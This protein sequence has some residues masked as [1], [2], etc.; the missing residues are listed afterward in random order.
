MP[1]LYNDSDKAKKTQAAISLTDF[2]VPLI[3]MWRI[4]FTNGIRLQP[5]DSSGLKQI[6][7]AGLACHKYGNFSPLRT[8]GI[9]LYGLFWL[10][11]VLLYAV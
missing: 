10:S 9:T 6:I 3:S 7:R 4:E 11:E 2:F 5:Y 8:K 1:E